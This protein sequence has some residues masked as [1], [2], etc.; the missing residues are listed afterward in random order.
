VLILLSAGSGY[1]QN[2][3]INERSRLYTEELSDDS[4]LIKADNDFAVP[5]SLRLD[6]E[7]SNL[8]SVEGAQVFAVLQPLS[9]G[10]VVARLKK[11]NPEEEFR[12]R[13][14]WRMVLGDV[15]KSPDAHQY[16]F[17]FSRESAFTVSQGPGENFSH[18]NSFAYDFV[19]P[20]GSPVKAARE[21]IVAFVETSFERGG[22]YRE[23]MDKANVISVLHE[24]GTI[25][26][27]VHLSPKG[28]LVKEGESVKAGQVIGFSGN[29]GYSTG[30]HLHFELIQPSYDSM[31]K[32]W[33]KF[34][35][36]SPVYTLGHS[37]HASEAKGTGKP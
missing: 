26:N 35:W 7:L 29:T 16:A 30:A 25:A 36:D 37:G 24:D 17:P 12:C 32:K 19:M 15:S 11:I 21:G 33:I 5:L 9:K 20:V 4:L 2:Y 18:H 28:S 23:L 34:D 13:Y 14:D 27:Y 6:L 3:R 1:S 31:D 22:P 10:Q 8:Q